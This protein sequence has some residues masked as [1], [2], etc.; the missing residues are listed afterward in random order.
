MAKGN[1][2]PQVYQGK[3]Y[4]SIAALADE[5]RYLDC[6]SVRVLRNIPMIWM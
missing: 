3:T 5:L 1:S 4:P 6:I 2:K